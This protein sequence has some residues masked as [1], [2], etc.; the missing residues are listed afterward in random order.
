MRIEHIQVKAHGVLKDLD[1]GP[2][3]NTLSVIQ[4]ASEGNVNKAVELQ[5]LLFNLITEQSITLAHTPTRS[6]Q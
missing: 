1:L 3:G 6:P 5:K 2:V 4:T